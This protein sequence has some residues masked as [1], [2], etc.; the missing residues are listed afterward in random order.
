M[1]LAGEDGLRVQ[2]L[3]QAAV[4]CPPIIF[5]TGY[6]TITMTVQALKAGAVDFLQKPFEEHA[7]FV[8]V[9][10]ALARPRDAG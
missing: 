7:L 3:L 9:R 5:L 10:D 1:R 8:A 6:G 4:W 2:Q